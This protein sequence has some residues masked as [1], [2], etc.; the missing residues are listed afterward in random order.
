M[1][2]HITVLK[3]EAVDALNI[4]DDGIY[5]DATLG[6]GGH[7]SLILSKLKKGH[8]YSFDQ[9]DYAISR[10]K[11]KLDTVGNNYTII[12]S[13][14]VNLKERLNELGVYHIDGI[15]YDLGVSSFQFDMEERG[16]SYRLDGPLDMRMNQNQE[17]SA[18][19][20]VNEWPVS[21]L[22][23]IFYRYGEE[24]FAKQIAF[25][26]DKVRHEKEISTT[27]ELVDIIKSALPQKVLKQKGHPAKQVFQALRV[28]VNDELTVF[29]KSLLDALDM[30]NSDG[31][32][33]VITFQS[34]EDRIC[35]SI[36]KEKS[37]LD[38]PEGLPVIIK[39]EAPFELISRK[40]IL[41]SEEELNNNNRSHSAKMRI[42][43]KR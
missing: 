37:T 40:P 1:S 4:K 18:K 36:F 32:A 26:I 31:R 42:L 21:K 17:L 11:E 29:E 8:L 13:N 16:F 2:E 5:V 43:R 12:K 19:T 15:L 41:P 10:A 7:S 39:E 25:Q 38:I 28:A 3:E 6:G 33:V 24:K 30:L 14:F 20:I 27:F 23:E 35:K 22:I 34:L 9:D